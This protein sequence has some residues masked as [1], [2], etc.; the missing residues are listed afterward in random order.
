MDGWRT[1]VATPMDGVHM[2]SARPTRRRCTAASRTRPLRQP[3]L[4]RDQSSTTAGYLPC[5]SGFAATRNSIATPI[6]NVIVN[7]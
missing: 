1:I 6:A 3:V 2:F 5:S 4:E 7:G